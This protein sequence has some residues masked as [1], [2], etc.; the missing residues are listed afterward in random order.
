[1]LKVKILE[2]QIIQKLLELKKNIGPKQ[3]SKTTCRLRSPLPE[4][5]ER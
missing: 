3:E 1:M 5:G 4:G 2:F